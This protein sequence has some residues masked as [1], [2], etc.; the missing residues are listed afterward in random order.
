MCGQA[1]YALASDQVKVFVTVQGGHMTAEFRGTGETL[2]PFYTAPWWKEPYMEDTDSVMRVLRGEFFC[3]PFGANVEPVDGRR[4]PLHG[5]T[6]NDCWERVRAEEKEGAATLILRMDLDQTRS[7]VEKSIQLADGEPVIYERHVVRGLSLKAPVAHH[8]ML[9]CP[10]APGS[11]IL[12][13]SPPLAG[14]TVPVPVDIPENKGCGLLMLN[15]AVADRTKVPTVYGGFADVSRYPL[16][17]GHEDG[18]I[19]LSDPARGFTFTSVTIPERGLLYFQLKDPR[20]F[21]QTLFWMSDGG[22]YSPPFNGRV[23][24]VLGAEEITGYFWMGIKPSIEPN[25][26]MQKGY[27][28]FVDFRREVRQEFRII[29]GTI[30]IPKDFTGVIDILRKDGKTVTIV[31]RTG[32]RIDVPCA[33]DWLKEGKE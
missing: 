30:P 29:I 24:G 5:H 13:L 12:D 14:F 3:L 11:A 26:L 18:V 28:T 8:P 32:Q 20:V 7:E 21:S 9:Q 22:R 10:E 6:A 17:R 27:R 23:T 15:V 19:F 31:G 16:R 33:V 25:D 1:C 2:A 4:F